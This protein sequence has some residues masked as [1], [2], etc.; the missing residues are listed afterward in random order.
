MRKALLGIVLLAALGGAPA[1]AP[2]GGG[3]DNTQIDILDAFPDRKR[4][5]SS[6]DSSVIVEVR[7]NRA[8]ELVV[9]KPNGKKI[10][11]TDVSSKRGAFA[12]VLRK[13]DVQNAEKFF[14]V[15]QTSPAARPAEREGGVRD[16]SR[17][18]RSRVLSSTIESPPE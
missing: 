18:A 17:E 14:R 9:K 15:E 11:D 1:I 4:A 8:V 16:L 3:S 13:Q 7:Q 10:A 2:A 12:V 6:L 5:T